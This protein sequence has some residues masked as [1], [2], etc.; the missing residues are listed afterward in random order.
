MDE[1][2]VA[3]AIEPFFSTKE[4]G[5]GT[6]LGL[7]MVEGLV[8]QLGGALRLSSD[9]GRGTTVELWLPISEEP[10][11]AVDAISIVV[12][13]ARAIGRVLLVD[14][15]AIVRAATAD[16]LTDTGYEVVEAA[17]A[18]EAMQILDSDLP[19]DFLVTD[20]LM[21]GTTGADL[22]QAVSEKRPEILALIISGFAGAETIAPELARLAKPFRQS[23]LAASLVDLRGRVI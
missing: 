14:D 5:K 19:F 23:E 9:L 2:T 20:L 6:G 7:S 1:A 21:P 4:T 8:A 13:D 3:R 16:M 18:N 15:E 12:P 17:S 11:R 22:V 10:I